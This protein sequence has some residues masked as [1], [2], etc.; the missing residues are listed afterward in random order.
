MNDIYSKW[1]GKLRERHHDGCKEMPGTQLPAGTQSGTLAALSLD[2]LRKDC[3]RLTTQV[4]EASRQL[5]ID[6]HAALEP[7]R[8]SVRDAMVQRARTAFPE[9]FAS[10]KTTEAELAGWL[11]EASSE[12]G[13]LA[14]LRGELAHKVRETHALGEGKSATQATVKELEQQRGALEAEIGGL[15]RKLM[16]TH[17]L[18][19]TVLDGLDAVKEDRTFAETC[20]RQLAD[21]KLEA[22]WRMERNVFKEFQSVRPVGGGA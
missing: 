4:G 9:A 3:Q 10:G 21:A 2:D 22:A 13:E 6:L 15:A 1:A 17:G 18:S 14:Y 20:A 19:Q 5:V 12:G 11:R 16:K 8:R 7:I